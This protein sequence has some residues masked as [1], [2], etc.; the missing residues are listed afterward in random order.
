[1]QYIILVSAGRALA[2]L[3][4]WK[5]IYQW[6]AIV[7]IAVCGAMSLLPIFLKRMVGADFGRLPDSTL[8]R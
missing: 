6:Q 7:G 4:S 3:H 2:T 5:D 1:M 8:P